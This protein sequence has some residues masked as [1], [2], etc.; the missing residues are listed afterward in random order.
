MAGFI[1]YR[2]LQWF[3]SK[4]K[5][6]F[7]ET[8]EEKDQKGIWERLLLS[9][10]SVKKLF[11]IFWIKILNN[12]GTS[13][14]AEKFFKLLLRWGRFSGLKHLVS[15]TP[16]EYGIRLGYRFPQIEK[17]ISLIIHVHDEAIYGCISPD[18]HQIS[19]ARLALRRI[20]SPLLWL[21][22]IKSLC[23]YNRF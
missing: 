11:A 15:E 19:R 4:I 9:I 7:S 1:L 22:R 16:K 8:V 3:Y 21:A 13:C 14:A 18:S 12:P 5:W 10:S 2:L 23:F 20:R 6:L 17:E